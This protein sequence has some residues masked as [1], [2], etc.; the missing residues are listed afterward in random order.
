MSNDSIRRISRRC[1]ES[2]ASRSPPISSRSCF[3][4]RKREPCDSLRVP[5]REPQQVDA[6]P[7]LRHTD[8]DACRP[9]FDDEPLRDELAVLELDRHEH[10]ARDEEIVL[11]EALND[12][13]EK[14]RRA[15]TPA[16][17][18][19]KTSFR[20][21]RFPSRMANTATATSPPSSHTPRRPRRHRLPTRP[22]AP[23]GFARRS[24]S[25]RGSSGRSRT[26]PP[27]QPRTS[28]AFSA[29]AALGCLPAEEEHHVVD[30]LPVLGSRRQPGDTGPGALV[31][32]VVEAGAR[33]GALPLDDLEIAGPK[34]ELV[35]RSASASSSPFRRR[36]GPK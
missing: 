33:H 21:T 19:Q 36:T 12:L 25:D 2:L 11:V 13:G 27:R 22:A 23:T 9:R 10:L 31:H 8:R 4:F 24:G 6:A 26:S 18:S 30:D 3:D 32:V 16:T 1:R 5:R 20:S 15:R 28:A 35:A 17:F 7:L 29:P 34:P 14:R